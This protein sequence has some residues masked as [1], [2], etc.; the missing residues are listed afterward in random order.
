VP[1][2]AATEIAKAVAPKATAGA[3]TEGYANRLMG[4]KK[5]AAEQIREQSEKDNG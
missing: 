2:G 5:R 4:A 3:P 1:S